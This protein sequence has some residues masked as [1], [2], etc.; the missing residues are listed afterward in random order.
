MYTSVLSLFCLISAVALPLHAQIDKS[1]GADV[2]MRDDI[3]GLRWT[4]QV[5]LNTGQR[6]NVQFLRRDSLLSVFGNDG[7]RVVNYYTGKV[8]HTTKKPFS[9]NKALHS[10]SRYLLKVEPS[11]ER[12]AGVLAYFEY[13]KRLDMDNGFRLDTFVFETNNHAPSHTVYTFQEVKPVPSDEH[14]YI[15]RMQCSY[16]HDGYS[17]ESGNL[18]LFDDRKQIP[19][20]AGVEVGGNAEFTISPDGKYCVSSGVTTTHDRIASYTDHY[21]IWR[22]TD[23]GL[24]FAQNLSNFVD[25]KFDPRSRF[26]LLWS[27]GNFV[28]RYLLDPNAQS[29]RS[30][31]AFNLSR[32]GQIDPAGSNY[33]RFDSENS[34]LETIRLANGQLIA[35]CNQGDYKGKVV[36]L[37]VSPLGDVV[38]LANDSGKIAAVNLCGTSPP[39]GP[40]DESEDSE[41]SPQFRPGDTGKR[42]IANAVHRVENRDRRACRLT[43]Y[44]LTGRAVYH[45]DLDGDAELQLPTSGWPRGVYFVVQHYDQTVKQ[46]CILI[47]D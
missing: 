22:I 18:L 32:L 39:P 37:S 10:N 27:E 28:Q 7:N 24:E 17:V 5:Q 33:V 20:D 11:E 40:S 43:V 19:T 12:A 6:A 26:L 4:M 35:Q 14:R 1:S 15:I 2:L 21:I 36:G 29:W 45:A 31:D 8:L 47:T 38:I 9:S 42:S 16:N 41:D 25:V 44:N 46:S 30:V 3:V 13:F 23:N 34:H